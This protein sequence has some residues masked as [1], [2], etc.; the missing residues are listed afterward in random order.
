MF[1]SSGLRSHHTG[2]HQIRLQ[3]YF[4][5]GAFRKQIEVLKLR[6][7]PWGMF[8]T[9]QGKVFLT[10]QGKV[11]L[12]I[13]GKVFFEKAS[14]LLYLGGSGQREVFFFVHYP[15]CTQMT[16]QDLS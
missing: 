5:K 3:K 16:C 15:Y 11:F 8:L 9:I 7:V 10:I 1:L 4:L 6:L 14:L 13:Q 2:S 12:T